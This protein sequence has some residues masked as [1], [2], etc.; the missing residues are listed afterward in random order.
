MVITGLYNVGEMPFHDVFIHPKILD[1]YGEGMSKSKGNGVDPIDVIEKFGADRPA[2]RPGLPDHRDAGHP[3]AGR[4]R[5]SALREADRADQ[6]EPRAAADQV[7]ALRQGVLHAMGR[8]AG[9][10]GPAARGGGERA[11]RAGAEFLQQALERLAVRADEPG[12][13]HARRRWPTPICWSRT[14]GSS[15]GWR[16]WHARGDRRAWPSIAMPTRRRVLYGFAW[17]EFCSF[18]VEMVKARLQRAGQRGRRP[19]GCWPTRSTRSCG[20]LHPMIPFVTEEVWQLVGGHAP[21]GGGST[22]SS[23]RPRAS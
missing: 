20:C 15:A 22:R 19:S 7:Q 3:H 13:L 9:R 6:G 18:Y 17:D 1:G 23:R 2:L 16:R 11:V 14:A 10:Q 8:K 4:V 21:R 12:R 5:V